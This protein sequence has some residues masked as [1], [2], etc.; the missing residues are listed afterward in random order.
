MP[1]ESVNKEILVDAPQEKA[2]KAFTQKLDKWWPRS[3]HIGKSEM[4]K[5][6]LEPK[7]GG[8][9][10]EIGEDGSECDWGKVLEWNPFERF[11]LAWQ[12]N[13]QW[14]FDPQLLTEVEVTFVS[15]GASKTRVTLEHRNLE[16]FGAAAV[17]IKK[18]FESEGGWTGL[19]KR[20]V[21]EA[22]R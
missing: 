22:E 14:Q 6:V 17:E 15:E 3:H 19:L 11:V 10:F 12:L 18:S 20:F 5:A 2:F 21:E 16:R 8:R 13:G 4:K 9:W 7:P 1:I